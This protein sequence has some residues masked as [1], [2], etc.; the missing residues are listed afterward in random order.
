M[1]AKIIKNINFPIAESSKSA[2]MNHYESAK[3]NGGE[4]SKAILIS[5]GAKG[6]GRCLARGCEKNRQPLHDGQNVRDTI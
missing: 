4:D 6:I 5:G 3:V 2:V 1:D